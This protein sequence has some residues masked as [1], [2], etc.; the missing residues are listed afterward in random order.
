MSDRSF[1]ESCLSYHTYVDPF[2]IQKTGCFL[3]MKIETSTS[4]S[5]NL[6]CIR[7][8]DP[9]E[10]GIL[11]ACENHLRL[12]QQVEK[13]P[14]L[15]LMSEVVKLPVSWTYRLS[16]VSRLDICGQ[17]TLVGSENDG[18]FSGLLEVGFISRSW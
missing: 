1:E 16:P 4:L 6:R 3:K 7:R 8:I 2:R 17:R 10:S 18:P 5:E 13:S 11:Y 15:L 9:F 14:L 12:C